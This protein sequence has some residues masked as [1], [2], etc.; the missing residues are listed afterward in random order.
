MYVSFPDIR[1]A[2]KDCYKNLR[3]MQYWGL[4]LCS[5]KQQIASTSSHWNS[6]RGHTLYF[7]SDTCCPR[8]AAAKG[9]S[10]GASRSDLL[11]A[12]EKASR[13]VDSAAAERI[14]LAAVTTAPE[15]GTKPA[16]GLPG[17]L[18]DV[19]AVDGSQA[20]LADGMRESDWEREIDGFIPVEVSTECGAGVRWKA[21]VDKWMVLG[22]DWVVVSRTA[23]ANVN[24]A[25]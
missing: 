6:A 2:W 13:Q 7:S 24:A 23:L 14:A 10:A 18:V 11:S 4:D 21:T 5:S 8:P 12:L 15:N 3:Q 19:E 20:G 17:V 1:P 22:N 9:Q 25:V 16:E